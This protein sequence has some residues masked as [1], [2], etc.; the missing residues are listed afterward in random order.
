MRIPDL[1][2][3]G[4]GIG[5]TDACKGC[6]AIVYGKSRVGHDDHCRHRVV[7]T[8]STNPKVAAR[9]KVAIGRD[10]RWH[11]KKLEASETRRKG[12]EKE[13]G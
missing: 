11:A 6:K 2:P 10:V 8:A 1:D 4:G 13:V 12:P 9:V 7:G 5:F 3:G